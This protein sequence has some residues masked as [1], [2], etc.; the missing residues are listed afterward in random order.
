MDYSTKNGAVIETEKNFTGQASAQ[1]LAKNVA[2]KED[3]T[4]GK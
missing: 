4:N 1:E 2:T 3:S